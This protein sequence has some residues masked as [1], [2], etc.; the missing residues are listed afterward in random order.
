L[1]EDDANASRIIKEI[2]KLCREVGK[3]GA[4]LVYYVGHGVTINS[5]STGKKIH[6]LAPLHTPDEEDEAGTLIQRSVIYNA[7]IAEKIRFV[8]LITDSCSN[9]IE[10]EL[11]SDCVPNRESTEDNK[12]YPH[13]NPFRKFNAM[14]LYARGR[15]DICSSDPDKK[16]SEGKEG[17]SAFF[18]TKGGSVFTREFLTA[19]EMPYDDNGKFPKNDFNTTIREIETKVNSYQDMP[20]MKKMK[21]QHGQNIHIYDNTIK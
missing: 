1:E 15:I 5:K 3:N 17:Q 18:T 8:G 10:A 21:A 14:L 20:G 2:R 11:P 12:N 6:C 9:V 4:V 7:L 19:F 16:N 13:K